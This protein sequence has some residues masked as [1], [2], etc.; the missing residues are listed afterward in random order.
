MLCLLWLASFRPV[1]AQSEYQFTATFETSEKVVGEVARLK[2][3]AEGKK[4]EEWVVGYQQVIDAHPDAVLSQ[5]EERL[6]G[7]R[8]TLNQTLADLPAVARQTYRRHYDAPARI[9]WDKARAAGDAET[10]RRIYLRYRH[11]RYGPRALRWIADRALDGGEYEIARLAYRRL[12]NETRLQPGWASDSEMAWLM[13]RWGTAA[14]LA[15]Q[16]QEAREA[17][18]RLAQ[19]Y[20]GVQLR[21]AGVP[22]RGA[23]LAAEERARIHAPAPPGADD[24]RMFSGRPAGGRVMIGAVGDVTRAWE[25]G[26]GFASFPGGSGSGTGVVTGPF[27]QTTL[28]AG[29]TSLFSH[30]AFPAVASDRVY[31]QTPMGSMAIDARDGKTLWT[32]G[33]MNIRPNLTV[34]RR[35]Y[36]YYRSLRNLQLAP[37]LA[38]PHLIMRVPVG[39]SDGWSSSRWPT[40]F[41]LA[42]VDART[43][44]EVWTRTGVTPGAGPA[45]PAGSYF[46]LPTV[47]TNTIYTGLATPV[48][49]L[50]EY[51]AIAVDAGTGERRW[52]AYLG[53]GSDPMAT[54]DGSPPAVADGVVW[55]ESSLHTL[56]ALDIVTGELLWI[57]RYAPRPIP[58]YRSGWNDS[59]TLPNEPI[60]LIARAGGHILFAPRWGDQCMAFEG[61][62]GRLLWS[63]PKGEA[64]SLFAA[65]ETHAYL[66]GNDVQALDLAT[67]AR[68]WS[69][70][71]PAS[72]PGYAALAGSRIYMPAGDT[73]YVLDRATG[74]QLAMLPLGPHGVEPGYAAVLVRGRQLLFTQPER[75]LAFVGSN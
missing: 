27:G 41:A 28:R 9:L 34:R 32:R 43:G 61:K 19:K 75:I 69:W 15:G 6:V 7:V 54:T 57:H 63:A 18:D 62:T 29:G 50:T 47:H 66:C 42:A 46:N 21:I 58:Y 4:W 2:K 30:L 22:R 74:R 5:G 71:V 60:S 14:T 48:A 67:G 33:N 10:I 52:T 72:P 12:L 51:R 11:T 59:M 25:V 56:N 73:I 16:G 65:D 44:G 1:S 45:V 20:G 39:P 24:W 8:A 40:E 38:G 64:R 36:G 17:F 53:T 49:G 35:S 23:D 3:L 37:A 13:L 68:R 70:S 31:L 55:I 26:A